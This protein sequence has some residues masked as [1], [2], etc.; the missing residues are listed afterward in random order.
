MSLRQ[1]RFA[2]ATAR[3]YRVSFSGELGYEINVPARYGATLWAELMK[4]GADFGVTPY[5][6]EAVLLLRLEKGYLH[7]GADTDGTTTPADVGWG[8]IAAKKKADFIGKRSLDAP[9]Q[10]ARGPTAARRTRIERRAHARARR[11]PATARHRRRQRRLGDLRRALPRARPARSR[12]RCCAAVARGSGRR[13][14][15]TTSSA[16]G[17][18]TVVSPDVPRPG[19]K[20]PA[21][22]SRSQ[23]CSRRRACRPAGA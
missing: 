3:L 8:E 19:R 23:R 15:C 22:L 5:G 9:R 20:A 12:L 6:L 1:G 13:S 2:G 18:A 4:N 7:V 21:C 17:E 10:P 14:S 16:S 11:A